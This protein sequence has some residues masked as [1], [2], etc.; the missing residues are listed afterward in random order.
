MSEGDH[1]IVLTKFVLVAVP[2][3]L[4]NGYPSANISPGG[5]WW[6][7]WRGYDVAGIGGGE[8]ALRLVLRQRAAPHY[9][10]SRTHTQVTNLYAFS[11]PYE[12]LP[13]IRLIIQIRKLR[14][15]MLNLYNYSIYYEFIC[16]IHMVRIQWSNWE[17][18]TIR[19]YRL[20]WAKKV[21]LAAI[22]LVAGSASLWLREN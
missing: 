16:Q 19:I 1:G 11:Q 14:I 12:L 22:C 9:P 6:G 18:V 15:H 5:G 13:R 10:W 17:D 7:V 2:S 4:P 8:F 21:S 3:T 20:D